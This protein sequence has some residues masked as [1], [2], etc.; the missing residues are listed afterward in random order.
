MFHKTQ[1]CAIFALITGGM[2]CSVDIKVW[3][4]T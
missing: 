2:P 3:K 4:K 1:F